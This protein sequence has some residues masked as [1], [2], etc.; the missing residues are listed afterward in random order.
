M[1]QFSPPAVR[2]PLGVQ[3]K[4]TYDERREQLAAGD[5]LVDDR[6]SHRGEEFE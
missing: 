3:S 1:K 4:L 2:L 6:W 5:I